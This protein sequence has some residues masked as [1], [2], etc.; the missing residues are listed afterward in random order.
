MPI[1]PLSILFILICVSAFSLSSLPFNWTKAFKN[2]KFKTTD[3][4][5]KFNSKLIHYFFYISFLSSIIFNIF[6]SYLNGFDLNGILFYG[7]EY[8]R[9]RGMNELTYNVFGRLSTFFIYMVPILGGFIAH[10][11]KNKVS[12]FKFLILSFTP[13]LFVMLTQSGK[14]QLFVSF[15]FYIAS[16]FLMKVY[17]NKLELLSK[18]VF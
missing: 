12:H 13:A 14:L 18:K 8:A 11:Q 7:G 16:I 17:S 15:G 5:N 1:N 4:Y 6:Q 3:D 2:N 9:R 10:H